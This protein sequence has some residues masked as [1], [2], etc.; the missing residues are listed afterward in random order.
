MRKSLKKA[1]EDGDSSNMNRI[2]ESRNAK[3]RAS[4]ALNRFIQRHYIDNEEASIDASDRIRE[5]KEG[6]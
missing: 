5:G 1:C 3:L 4:V 6:V 2:Y